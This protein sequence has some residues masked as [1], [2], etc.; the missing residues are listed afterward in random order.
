MSQNIVV[1]GGGNAGIPIFN[2]LSEK[3][4][5]SE[6]KIILVTP[7]GHFTSLPA[8][9]RMVVTSEG[10]LENS[11]LMP[12]PPTFNQ[13][14]R[15][16]VLA[17]VVSIQDDKAA[18]RFVTLDNGENIEF[19]VLVLAP[20]SKWEGP[21]DFPENRDGQLEWIRNWRN[22][23][24]KAK[25]IVLVGGGSVGVELSGELKDTFPNKAITIVHGQPFL[26]NQA[27][28]ESFR[29]DMGKRV[30]KRGTRLVLNDYVD[31]FIPKEGKVIT[32]K[33]T[34]IPAD[35]VVATRGPKPNTE[36]IES[37]GPDALNS[38][39]FVKVRQT[40]QLANHPRIFAAGDV[41]DVAEEKQAAKTTAHAAVVVANV[42]S[43]I[44]GADDAKPLVTYKGSKELI[45]ITNGKN[46]G[47]GYFDVLWGITVGDFL[48]RA[49]KSKG[50]MI[51]VMKKS[52]KL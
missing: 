18:G 10:D 46:G 3:L 49:T 1:V 11:V 36:F 32:R 22:D 26:L 33:G 38:T 34:V 43:I 7:R 29:K 40:L 31:D 47:A 25:S 35:L 2:A 12:F 42:V 50:L 52:L 8:T 39:G 23:F 45:L 13:G 20:G 15:K 48:A 41:I 17:K 51:D 4:T 30:T 24:A 5:A 28:P 37:L 14:N 16:V 21:I 6:A 27:Y 9:L 44:R 19:S